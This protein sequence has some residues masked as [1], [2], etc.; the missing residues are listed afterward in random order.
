MGDQLLNNGIA[1][2]QRELSNKQ[3][4][5]DNEWTK[6]RKLIEDELIETEKNYCSGLVTLNGMF[7]EIF[8]NKWIDVKLKSQCL[9]NLPST[10]S[11][12]SVHMLKRLINGDVVTCFIEYS[13][14]FKMYIKYVN[15]YDGILD[16]FAKSKNKKLKNISKR[17]GKKRSR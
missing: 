15:E 11:F 1:T 5:N 7:D 16:I 3:Q 10:A 17:R 14:Y 6:K 13:D 4:Q 2:L 8:A 12:H 9:S